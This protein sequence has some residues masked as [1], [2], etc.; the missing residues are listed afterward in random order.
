M[1]TVT[2]AAD[3][4]SPVPAVQTVVSGGY[5]T[6]PAAMTKGDNTFGGWYKEADFTTQWNFTIDTVTANVTLYAKWIEPAVTETGTF[7]IKITGIPGSVTAN[8]KYDHIVIGMGQANEMKLDGTNVIAGWSAQTGVSLTI[9]GS[10]KNQWFQTYMYEIGGSAKYTG[11][12]GYYDIGLMVT[13]ETN[14]VLVKGWRNVRL[15]VNTV[16]T[17]AYGDAKDFTSGAGETP[18]S[19]TITGISGYTGPVTIVI[20][21]IIVDRPEQVAATTSPDR[22]VEVAVAWGTGTVSGKSVEIPLKALDFESPNCPSF[23][24]KDW[25]P[26]RDGEYFVALFKTTPDNIFSATATPDLVLPA[27]V[28]FT[29]GNNTSVAWEKFEP[30]N[31][32]GES[33]DP[34]EKQQEGG[35]EGGQPGGTAESTR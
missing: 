16:T 28:F 31:N 13:G 11:T 27:L 22:P 8:D 20:T 3:G 2:F 7:E 25:Q 29:E 6:Q 12:A 1:V 14:E 24:D 18:K 4:G 15:E 10:G 26:D 33:G 21:T 32:G 5:A 35:E 34:E 23:I 17:F 9:D 30:I 19:L